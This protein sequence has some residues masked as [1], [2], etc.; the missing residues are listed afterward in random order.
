MS[1]I[2]PILSP[3]PPPVKDYNSRNEPITGFAAILASLPGQGKVETASSAAQPD[4]IITDKESFDEVGLEAT[5]LA[6]AV[7]CLNIAAAGLTAVD[8]QYTGTESAGTAD[9]SAGAA[10]LG[11][12]SIT[13]Q[14]AVH[15]PGFTASIVPEVLPA[16]QAVSP[17][18]NQPRGANTLPAQIKTVVTAEPEPGM[19]ACAT[20]GAAVP[21]R[22]PFQP[23]GHPESPVEEFPEG[24]FGVR[25]ETTPA[26][27][28]AEKT[29]LPP[30]NREM[31]GW[32]QKER[33]PSLT[34][35]NGNGTHALGGENIVQIEQAPEDRPKERDGP[36]ISDIPA[37][38]FPTDPENAVPSESAPRWNV[39]V[40]S[41][42]KAVV[43]RKIPAGRTSSPSE[44]KDRGEYA[45]SSGIEQPEREGSVKLPTSRN[46]VDFSQ[47]A[48]PE[49][50]V[51]DVAADYTVNLPD[52]A[53]IFDS[54][55]PERLPRAVAV[56][57]QAAE[58]I[59]FAAVKN[60]GLAS[61]L[62]KPSSLGRMSLRLELANGALTAKFYV[63]SSA[64][65]EVLEAR[66]P[67][68]RADLQ[69]QGIA[70]EDAFVYLQQDGTSANLRQQ[71]GQRTYR[72][73][74]KPGLEKLEKSEEFRLSL[75]EARILNYVV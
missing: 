66:L 53:R 38:V 27:A 60:G 12:L 4:E 9:A 15:L 6:Q 21:A 43:D 50:A 45:V 51:A 63:E 32:Q 1:E 44:G 74:Y 75:S 58:N 62:L 46:P 54:A 17:D 7:C 33:L 39:E 48:P 2:Q 42:S 36:G 19:N 31:A 49:P 65:R 64:V 35:G 26:A 37:N 57:R 24:W 13:S 55:E 67:E 34:G 28:G 59:R 41:R 61:V 14:N 68:L 52:G 22:S 11:Q 69:A 72:R 20:S 47:A 70:C 18:T 23:E 73:Q 8:Q 71:T 40:R 25:A 5:I 3:L 10:G 56:F 29:P 30:E 16:V